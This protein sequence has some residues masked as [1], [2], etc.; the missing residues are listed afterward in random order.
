MARWRTVAHRSDRGRSW[1]EMTDVH[2]GDD[3]IVLH[4]NGK[5]AI[6]TPPIRFSDR[7]LLLWR[8]P[9]V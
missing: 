7:P 4:Q 8:A 2:V 3:R 5:I 6:M 1:L 9:K